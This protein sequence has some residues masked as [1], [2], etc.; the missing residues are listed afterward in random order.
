VCEEGAKK[1]NGG[2]S[3]DKEGDTSKKWY[4]IKL[5]QEPAFLKGYWLQKDYTSDNI[6]SK[7]SK[8][9]LVNGV[10]YIYIKTSK[11]PK[12]VKVK[13]QI[14]DS[15][16]GIFNIDDKAD[17]IIETFVKEIPGSKYGKIEEKVMLCLYDPN[18]TKP[19]KPVGVSH[20]VNLFGASKDEDINELKLYFEVSSDYIITGAVE[21]NQETVRSKE[22][23]NNEK[24]YLPVKM[25]YYS[26]APGAKIK[27]DIDSELISEGIYI[28]KD[29]E[30]YWCEYI[31]RISKYHGKQIEVK[32]NYSKYQFFII[33]DGF[34]GFL[35]K[36]FNKVNA[37][38]D[39]FFTDHLMRTGKDFND[40]L[41]L[42]ENKKYSNGENIKLFT[43][44][45]L[46]IPRAKYGFFFRYCIKKLG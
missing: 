27:F 40:A 46:I 21:E 33:K 5:Y 25:L 12:G 24:D 2:S 34:E 11:I 42:F 26:K 10:A 17:G 1:I 7:K 4:N 36:Q 43:V 3:S 35:Q 31:K 8:G 44:F 15:D 19:T 14:K 39:N 38:N 32:E 9:C 28:D 30:E 16:K 6:D 13:I 20:Q 29:K 45:Q 23:P 18:D 22:F 37:D 41:I